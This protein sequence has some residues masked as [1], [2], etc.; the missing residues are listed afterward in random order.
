MTQRS[1]RDDTMSNR[2]NQ[3]GNLINENRSDKIAKLFLKKT[4][5]QNSNFKD[6]RIYYN[7]DKKKHIIN[8]CL[9]FKQKNFQINVIKDS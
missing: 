5:K 7:C 2:S 6:E 3:T 4:D 8:K 1:R 9:K